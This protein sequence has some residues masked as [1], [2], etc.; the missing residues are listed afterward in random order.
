MLTC[1]SDGSD[2]G[3]VHL[4]VGRATNLNRRMDQWSRQCGSK[5]QVLRGHWPDGLD[6]DQPTMRG[7]IE[8]GSKG[9]WCHRLERLVH[10]ELADLA[11]HAP[12][13]EARYPT[14]DPPSG[15]ATRKGGKMDIKRCPDCTSLFSLSLRGASTKRST[16]RR[17]ESQGNLYIREGQEGSIQGR[18]MDDA[19]QASHREVGRLCR[20]ISLIRLGMVRVRNSDIGW[21]EGRGQN[22][23]LY[24]RRISLLYRPLCIYIS[25][26]SPLLH[27][28]AQH[29]S[30][31]CQWPSVWRCSLLSGS[32][33]SLQAG[34]VGH[35]R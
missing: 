18:R 19:R 32:P 10:I 8:A 1:G 5:E 27:L 13:H 31:R 22:S 34:T 12:Y 21:I 17:H 11:T 20:G 35:T 33:G 24:K 2:D 29:W 25:P 3:V 26:T 30:K 15:S 6:G 28:D 7:L 14:C 16:D 9:K 23:E 4:K